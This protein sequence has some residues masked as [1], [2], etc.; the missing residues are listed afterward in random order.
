MNT[1][2]KDYL[3]STQIRTVL[4][5]EKKIPENQLNSKGGVK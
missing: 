3:L 2:E 4:L 5:S 1:T